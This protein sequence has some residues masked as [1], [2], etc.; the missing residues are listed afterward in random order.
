MLKPKIALIP[1]AQGNRFYSVL[2]MNGDGDFDYTR[3]ANATRTNEQ[4]FLENC[5]VDE[6]RLNYNVLDG[7]VSGCPSYLLEPKSENLLIYSQDF[8]QSQWDKVAN[9]QITSNSIISPYGILNGSKL[10]KGTSVLSLRR[11]YVITTGKTYTFSIYAKKG[12]SD[13]LILDIAD[14]PSE[15]FTLYD[16]WRRIEI[17]RDVV[18]TND[19]VDISFDSD[20]IQGD[21]V[22]IFGAQLETDNDAYEGN[23]ATSYIPTESVSVIRKQETAIDSGNSDIINSQKGMIFGQIKCLFNDGRKKTIAL[24]D[25]SANNDNIIAIK[26]ERDIIKILVKVDGVEQVLKG[27]DI[28]DITNLSKVVLTYSKNDCNL[29]IDGF[30]VWRDAQADVPEPKTLNTFG[31][32]DGL[33][34]ERYF[35][36]VKELL[37]YDDTLSFN[38]VE[39]MSSWQSYKQMAIDK[40]YINI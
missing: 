32:K 5:G 19:W 33:G 18:K 11:R 25:G 22:Y 7:V 40:E 39:F 6:S 26:S 2:P 21:S 13:K 36:E 34:Y 38:Q 24:S 17:T 37:Y 16:Y 31:F 35:G 15:T 27:I 12:T 30:R 28:F 14:E 9:S 10:Q 20:S 23:Y 3:L 1:S 29:W 8:T 4:G